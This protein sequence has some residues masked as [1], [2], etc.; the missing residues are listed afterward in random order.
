MKRVAVTAN[1]FLN[2]TALIALTGIS[3]H[4]TGARLLH[5]AHITAIG[6][7]VL[8]F[9]LVSMFLW[10]CAEI[11]TTQGR[12]RMFP[13]V[14]AVATAAA[15]YHYS[16]RMPSVINTDSGTQYYHISVQLSASGNGK[17]IAGII[18]DSNDPDAAGSMLPILS[19]QC[20]D[21]KITTPPWN[22]TPVLE[23]LNAHKAALSA[24][25]AITSEDGAA[26]LLQRLCVTAHA[27]YPGLVPGETLINLKIVDPDGTEHPVPVAP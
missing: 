19:F 23:A 6:H 9:G 10:A 25:D 17:A 20:T 11:Y 18:R 13:V 16:L 26:D 15:A 2:L 22:L 3:V 4:E 7:A 21:Q 27:H 5:N 1:L 14:V 24:E 12:A 8:Y